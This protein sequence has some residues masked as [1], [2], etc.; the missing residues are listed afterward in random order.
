MTLDKLGED[1]FETVLVHLDP[2]L[3][4]FILNSKHIGSQFDESRV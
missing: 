4:G 2:V 3:Q 1:I